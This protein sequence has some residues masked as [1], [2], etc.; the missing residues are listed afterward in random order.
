MVDEHSS[1]FTGILMINYLKLN[2][3]VILITEQIK[4][5]QLFF[6]EALVQQSG[7][8]AR[9]ALIPNTHQVVY[10]YSAEEQENIHFSGSRLFKP[11]TFYLILSL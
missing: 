3:L 2:L 1:Q 8:C 9:D 10:L 7:Q 4:S 5:L 11:R 6:E